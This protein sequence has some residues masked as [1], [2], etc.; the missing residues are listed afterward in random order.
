MENLTLAVMAHIVDGPGECRHASIGVS[1]SGK[2]RASA[3]PV[4]IDRVRAMTLRGDNIAD[5]LVSILD[6]YVSREDVAK[7]Y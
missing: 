5:D 3:A 7:A 4:F 1:L 2:G 6:D